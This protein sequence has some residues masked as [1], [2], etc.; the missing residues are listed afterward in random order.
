M[1]NKTIE[2]MVKVKK[3]INANGYSIKEFLIECN[4][5]KTDVKNKISKQGFYNYV[6]GTSSIN[7]R[8][9]NIFCITLDIT[10]TDIICDITDYTQLIKKPL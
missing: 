8:Q 7:L 1:N 3:L 2:I 5:N 9:L 10:L 6:N 4:E